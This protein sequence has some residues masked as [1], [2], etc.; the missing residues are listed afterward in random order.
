MGITVNKQHEH[1]LGRCKNELRNKKKN[2]NSKMFVDLYD[3]LSHRCHRHQAGWAPLIGPY[4]ERSTVAIGPDVCRKEGSRSQA[5]TIMQQ[6]FHVFPRKMRVGM[7]NL[8]TGGIG[9]SQRSF[10]FLTALVPFIHHLE[11][12]LSHFTHN[13]HLKTEAYRMPS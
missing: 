4:T 6:A 12:K 8:R 10:F 13:K 5:Y 2:Q 9:Q 3:Q 1:S 7:M 11:L